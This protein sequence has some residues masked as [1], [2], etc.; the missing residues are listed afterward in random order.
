[1][2]DTINN[3]IEFLNRNAKTT[4]AL[5]VNSAPLVENAR[6]REEAHEAPFTP[7]VSA[8]GPSN[9]RETIP[10][11]VRLSVLSSPGT[12]SSSPSPSPSSCQFPIDT[13]FSPSPFLS[14][15][16]SLPHLLSPSPCYHTRL[17]LPS[18]FISLPACPFMQC[19]FF[20]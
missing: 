12:C 2:V 13:L 7:C 11:P 16:L 8:P 6:K 9:G 15:H 19:L 10:P 18:P 17:A 20:F 4:G 1:M 14:L 5:L 3:R